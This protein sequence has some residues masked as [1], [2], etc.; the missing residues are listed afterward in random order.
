MEIGEMIAITFIKDE[1][2]ECPFE[3][4]LPE[5]P[6]VKNN[7]VGKGATLAT[8]MNNGTSTKDNEQFKP[9]DDSEKIKWGKI[10]Q[11]RNTP[12]VHPFYKKQAN[13]G[14][15]VEVCFEG[16]SEPSVKD[17]PVSC[18][19]HH[20][21]PSQESLKDH[22]LLEYMCK[23]DSSGSN[24]H[25][26]SDGLVWSDVGYNTNGS[27]NG[28]YLPGS[29]AVGG[30][31][32]GLRVWYPY[33]DEDDE[34][35]DTAYIE[36][37]KLPP[38]EYQGFELKGKRG[39]I[40]KDNPCWQYVSEAMRLAPGQFHDRHYVYS[41][42]VVGDALTKLHELCEHFNV[43]LNPNSCSDCEDRRKKIEDLGIPAPYSLVSHLESISNK[44]RTYLTAGKGG[45]RRN[46][47]TSEWVNAYMQAVI[48]AGNSSGAAKALR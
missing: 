6:N 11:K 17:Y 25:G 9:K 7:L 10:P 5:P 32:G 47:Y 46:I 42:Q 21:I 18:S 40:S 13:K 23:E 22:L 3:H 43:T 37:D 16:E 30:G 20:L 41:D 39:H 31:R 28:V 15:C 48:K 27:E 29:Y 14:R 2:F 35:H 34:E 45:W 44:L 8:A 38:S 19:A 12:K 26:F 24:N 36:A 4:E 1:K 33:D